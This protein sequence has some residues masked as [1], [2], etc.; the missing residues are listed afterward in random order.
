MFKSKRQ[1]EILE[2]TE[3][4]LARMFEEFNAEKRPDDG[5]LVCETQCTMA[6]I[7]SFS[8]FMYLMK[9]RPLQ[10][11]CY[12][13][14]AVF[15]LLTLAALWCKE[16]LLA[17]IF[18]VIFLILATLPH[19]MRI[20]YFNKRADKL[21]D[22]FGKVINAD[23]TGEDSVKLTISSPQEAESDGANRPE[24]G[25]ESSARTSE[26]AHDKNA[27][28]LEIPYEK[29]YLAYECSHSFYLF[30]EKLDENTPQAVICDKT[31]FLCGTPM[32]LRD[33]LARGCGKR[34]KIRIKKA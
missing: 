17:V 29:I 2:S 9:V 7:R 4:K 22:C 21:E 31:Q 18:G 23:F 26:A 8:D 19:N 30:P 34:F 25:E 6:R 32:R 10:T 28:T 1:K 33:R 11:G 13:G 20:Q 12:Y 5:R 24:R 3:S 14:A 16:W 15:F 27:L